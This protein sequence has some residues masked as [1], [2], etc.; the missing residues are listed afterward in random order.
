MRPE[1]RRH[2]RD[3]TLEPELV[4][5]AA[6]V[7]GA[8]PRAWTASEMPQ[9]RN[10]RA[11][12]PIGQRRSRDGKGAEQ[13]QRLGR[14]IDGV[15]PAPGTGAPDADSLNEPRI[16][17]AELS[18]VNVIEDFSN[19]DLRLGSDHFTFL[20]YQPHSRTDGRSRRIVGTRNHEPS[21]NPQAAFVL[22]VTV[23]G[24]MVTVAALRPAP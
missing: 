22:V 13:F 17:H 21:R 5:A 4:F 24:F 3:E 8:R 2:N 15:R 7:T 10:P 11:S 9:P 12:P 1:R 14:R 20:D 18:C 16:S 19:E 23:R 6:V